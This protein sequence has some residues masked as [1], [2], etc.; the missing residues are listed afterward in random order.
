MLIF[1]PSALNSLVQSEELRSLSFDAGLLGILGKHELPAV[2]YWKFFH[3]ISEA[4]SF[5]LPWLKTQ[6]FKCL[7]LMVKK[8]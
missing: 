4:A 6:E 7:S 2:G 8:C 5:L 1:I 3:L